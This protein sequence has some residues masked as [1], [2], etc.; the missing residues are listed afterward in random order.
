[1]RSAQF[2]NGNSWSEVSEMA[3]S[4]ADVNATGTSSS[5]LV[6]GGYNP[7]DAPGYDDNANKTEEWTADLGNLT[8][9]SS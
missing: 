8:I 4:R 1:M 6:F 7:A 9:T 3:N 5:G 2:W